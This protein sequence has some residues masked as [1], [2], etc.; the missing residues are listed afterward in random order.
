MATKELTLN[1]LV[2]NDF[3]SG[4][5]IEPNK[6]AQG[7]VYYA[8]MVFN[9]L[10]E[11]IV[12]NSASPIFGSI[13]VGGGNISTETAKFEFE[14][15]TYNGSSFTALSGWTNSFTVS[16][17]DGTVSNKSCTIDGGSYSFAIG[18]QLAYRVKVSSNNSARVA[19]TTLSTFK[20]EI[21]YTVQTRKVTVNISP[22]E[23][24]TVDGSG[25]YTYGSTAK[26]TANPNEGYKFVGW[27]NQGGAITTTNNPYSF[28]VGADTTFSAIFELDRINLILVDKSQ[29]LGVIIDTDT[30]DDDEVYVDTTKVYG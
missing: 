15:G 19:K 6:Y 14:F 30:K 3:N 2:N 25:D 16:E 17:R 7:A 11:P 4:D 8:T 5:T 20:L 24:G 10:T 27:A 12:L 29:S 9:A 18:T 28:T 22:V 13:K 21:D 1:K 26:V 23:G